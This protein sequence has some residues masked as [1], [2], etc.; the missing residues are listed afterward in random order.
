MD[1][2]DLSGQVALVTG[3]G[4]GLGRAFALAL[5]ARGAAVALV[6]RSAAELAETARLIAGAGGR[7]L[8]EAADVAD[9][10]AVAAA[11]ARVEREL[12]GVDLL[13]NNAAMATPIGPIAEVD[14]LQWWRCLEVNLK[15]PLLTARAVLPGMIARRR[16]RI[17][18]VASMVATT[19]VAHLSAYSTSKAALLRLTETLAA[20][21]RPQGVKV[22][23]MEPGTVRTAM[24]E[25][26]LGSVEG[27]RWVPWFRSLF[28]RGMDVPPEQAALVLARI[29]AGHADALTGRLIVLTDPIERMV[30]EADQVMRGDLYTLR[31]KRLPER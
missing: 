8:A 28:D 6:A 19:A 12:G 20:E 1:S 2:V 11:C 4:R 14:P 23:S 9:P 22:F 18:N 3:A 29:A 26:V 7:A 31:L 25:E 17:V 16:G 30:A 13:V 10:D 27:Q 15:G 21:V 5:A 24:S